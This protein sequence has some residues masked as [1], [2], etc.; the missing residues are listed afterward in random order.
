MSWKPCLVLIRFVLCQA[1]YAPS[2]L[3]V[4][5]SFYFSYYE[6]LSAINHLKYLTW[7]QGQKIIKMMKFFAAQTSNFLKVISNCVLNFSWS[8]TC[9]TVKFNFYFSSTFLNPSFQNIS[10]HLTKKGSN[11]RLTNVCANSNLL[12]LEVYRVRYSGGCKSRN[13]QLKGEVYFQYNNLIYK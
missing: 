13:V 7:L 5:G 8:K 6:C 4:K 9:N 3:E 10:I 12:T 11:C 1:N 2:C